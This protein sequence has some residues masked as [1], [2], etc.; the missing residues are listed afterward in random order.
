MTDTLKLIADSQAGDEIATER[1]LSIIKKE[2]MSRHTRRYVNRNV[3][4][5]QDEIESEFLVGCWKAI[6][7][8]KLDVGNPLNFIC[9]KGELAILHLFR[10]NLRAGVKVNCS[11]CGTTNM[12]YSTASKGQ[13]NTKARP[14]K[15]GIKSEICCSRCGA[16]DVETFMT[17]VDQSQMK[18]EIEN[19]TM[20]P[21]DRISPEQVT[22]EMETMFNQ[23]TYDMH[24]E[25]IRAKLNGRV[26]QLFDKL[27]VE[28]VNRDTSKNYLE[29]IAQEWGVSTA[30]VS[31]YLR[32]LRYKVLEHLGRL[33]QQQ[34]AA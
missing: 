12:T 17:T 30:A 25:E 4:V 33:P 21:W 23:I 18:E 16:T 8:A 10:K 20:Q 32:K 14:G 34:V 2:H 5:T 28:Q 7:K 24:V 9:W 29:E 13:I 1:L 26:L 19:G 3:L 31:V 27:V 15:R 11:T 6:P 22:D